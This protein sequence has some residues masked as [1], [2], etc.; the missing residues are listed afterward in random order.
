MSGFSRQTTGGTFIAY[1]KDPSRKAVGIKV[2]DNIEQT[3]V[4]S[5]VY[6]QEYVSIKV[7]ELSPTEKGDGLRVE[8]DP[9]SVP[10]PAGSKPLRKGISANTQA[11]GEIEKALRWALDSDAPLYV[12][13]EHRRKYKDPSGTVIPYDTPILELKGFGEN[14]KATDSAQGTSLRNISKVIAMIGPVADPGTALISPE[15]QS[16]PLE[17]AQHRDNRTG[18]TPAEG[19]V[20][21]TRPDG[22]PGGAAITRNTWR[23]L[24]GAITP[25]GA[26]SDEQLQQLAQLVAEQIRPDA[27]ADRTRPPHR[28]TRSA[29]ARRW[30]AY[31]SDGRINPGSYAVTGAIAARATALTVLENVN[32]A[33]ANDAGAEGR[34]PRLL[35]QSEITAAATKLMSALES[36]TDTVQ[37]AMTGMRPNRNDGSHMAA[38]K[39]VNQVVTR[40]L[41][42]TRDIFD[43]DAA[44]REWLASVQESAVAVATAAL[45][46]TAEHFDA[47]SD[48]TPVNDASGRGRRESARQNPPADTQPS[49][50]P[51]ASSSS[52]DSAAHEHHA[53]SGTLPANRD[54]TAPATPNFATTDNRPV[55]SVRQRNI[56]AIKPLL[57]ATRLG[58]NDVLPLLRE[59]FR[60]SAIDEIN[61]ESLTATVAA[62]TTD[63]S[64]FREAARAAHGRATT[65]AA[66]S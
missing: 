54:V 64:R 60:V 42:M 61:P 37:Q 46:T 4:H 36:V 11:G 30:D 38:G 50:P 14:G 21:I 33:E 59:T 31:N 51:A 8:F 32:F 12:G 18:T 48:P 26:F 5:E 63:P 47:I 40:E 49:G 6:I 35:T 62:W 27:S 25:G 28:S 58:A 52:S 3:R 13:V 9:A 2:G 29:E 20:R 57:T 17:W 24:N 55:E 65:P 53:P 19:W 7:K 15:V 56:A 34:T 66:A 41:L 44:K 43:D 16:D 23:D 22:T 45:A 1:T 39:A 10:V